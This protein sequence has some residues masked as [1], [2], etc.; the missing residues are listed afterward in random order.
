MCMLHFCF[1]HL[2]PCGQKSSQPNR[3]CTDMIKIK[4]AKNVL[5]FL[6]CVLSA[7]LAHCICPD[8]WQCLSD[9]ETYN[10]EISSEALLLNCVIIPEP[11]FLACSQRE[12]I[13]KCKAKIRLQS[14]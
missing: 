13:S 9:C 14:D 10:T 3:D 1:P 2:L 7:K 8:I 12:G 11:L 5:L 4:A 6:L